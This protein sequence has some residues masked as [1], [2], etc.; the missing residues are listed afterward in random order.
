MYKIKKTDTR[1]FK[2]KIVQHVHCDLSSLEYK[3]SPSLI[4]FLST[5]LASE[6]SLI[7]IFNN[8]LFENDLKSKLSGESLNRIIKIGRRPPLSNPTLLGHF[9]M[10]KKTRIIKKL[11]DSK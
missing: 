8:L 3:F 9:L 6:Y 1:N 11:F 4:P 2:Y 7:R 10:K 5:L